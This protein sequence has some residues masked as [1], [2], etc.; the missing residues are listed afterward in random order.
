MSELLR[1]RWFSPGDVLHDRVTLVAVGVIVGLLI[2]SGAVTLVLGQAGLISEKL[3]R[4]IMLRWRSWLFITL[5]L[6]IPIVLGPAW[7]MTGTCLL[8]LLCYQEFAR[9]TG[10]FREKTISLFVVLGDGKRLSDTVDAQIKRRIRDDCSLRHVPDEIVQIAEVP[11]TRSGKVL[12][13]PVKRILMGVQA[14]QVVSRDS[15]VNAAALDVF[16]T[17]AG[18][19]AFTASLPRAPTASG[20]SP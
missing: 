13:L 2:L 4:E 1:R 15:L 19:P 3:Y 12:E 11:R 6:F 10:L 18:D 7:V 16:V 20:G 9:A 5:I 17:L 14:D 8:S